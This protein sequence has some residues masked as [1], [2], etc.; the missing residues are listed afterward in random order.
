[1][2]KASD[3]L[4]RLNE[5]FIDKFFAT[6]KDLINYEFTDDYELA[7][8]LDQFLQSTY[9]VNFSLTRMNRQLSARYLPHSQVIKVVAPEDDSDPADVFD[10]LVTV[11]H[12]LSHHRAIQ[13]NPVLFK[14]Y[15]P[16]DSVAAIT[17]NILQAIERSAYAI[18]ICFEMRNKNFT[19]LRLVQLANKFQHFDCDMIENELKKYSLDLQNY[20]IGL[21]IYALSKSDKKDN[22]RQALLKAITKAYKKVNAYMGRFG[23]GLVKGVIQ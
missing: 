2:S 6:F 5:D 12:E 14:N 8:T 21:I 20:D 22:R 19:V 4:Y 1:M 18:S 7:T 10:I 15:K 13:A 9:G 11:L 17:D 23:P 16:L 3:L